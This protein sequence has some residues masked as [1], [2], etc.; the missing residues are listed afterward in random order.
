ML[1]VVRQQGDAKALGN[2]SMPLTVLASLNDT[3]LETLE[4]QSGP[5]IQHLDNLPLILKVTHARAAQLT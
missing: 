2:P 5:I 4:N 1:P 3:A